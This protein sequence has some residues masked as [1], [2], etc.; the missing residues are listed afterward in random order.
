MQGMAGTYSFTIDE[1]R[2]FVLM[3]LGG[4]FAV[5][6]IVAFDLARRAA[7]RQLRCKPNQHVTLIDMR[8]TAIQ[9]Q[10]AVDAFTR[11]INDP[12]TKSRRVAFVVSKSLARLQVQR[13]ASKADA[14][15][16]TTPEEAKLWLLGARALAA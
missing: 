1:R 13:V 16:F 5:E 11:S 15:Y 12:A 9:S 14:A 7:Y 8:A 6:E 2:D 3:K 4:F 10:E